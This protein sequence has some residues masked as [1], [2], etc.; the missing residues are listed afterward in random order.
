MTLP[1]SLSRAEPR[2]QVTRGHWQAWELAF[3]PSP[4]P[5][6]K[7]WEGRASCHGLCMSCGLRCDRASGP[8]E[9]EGATSLRHDIL[10]LAPGPWQDSLIHPGKGERTPPSL[11]QGVQ[12]LPG[13]WQPRVT[14]E[15]LP[16]HYPASLQEQGDHGRGESQGMW[17]GRISGTTAGTPLLNQ[18]GHRTWKGLVTCPRSHSKLV[19]GGLMSTWQGEPLVQGHPADRTCRSPS[20]QTQRQEEEDGRNNPE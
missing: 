11:L 13:G 19:A 7:H 8:L 12:S 10:S 4:S 20:S 18:Q 6:P 9:P 15:G 1:G 14:L 17:A 5:H 2:D 16:P 3:S